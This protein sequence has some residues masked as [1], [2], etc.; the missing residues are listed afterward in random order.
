MNYSNCSINWASGSGNI[1]I[2]EFFNCNKY[3][4]KYGLDAMSYA[5]QS[6]HVQVLEWFK[7]NG[8]RFK[9]SYVINNCINISCFNFFF[10]NIHNK[11][12]IKWT[13]VSKFK[14]NNFKTKTNYIKGYNKN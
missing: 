9:Y 14:M 11:K 2:L 12:F 5:C 4:F 13:K 8:Y 3:K 6:G 7:K 10:K 1:K